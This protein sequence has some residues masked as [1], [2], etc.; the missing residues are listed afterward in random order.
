MTAPIALEPLVR[1]RQPRADPRQN[2]GLE[3]LA[4]LLAVVSV[5]NVEKVGDALC[6]KALG[7]RDG[8]RRDMPELIPQTD[9]KTKTA[10]FAQIISGSTD[11]PDRQSI[12][13]TTTSFKTSPTSRYKF[14]FIKIL[15]I[16]AKKFPILGYYS[17]E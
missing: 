3:P 11:L 15:L 6:T 5:I 16:F 8:A 7:Q 2:K 1:E 17:G 12:E 4:D 13:I 10:Q 14:L 9:A